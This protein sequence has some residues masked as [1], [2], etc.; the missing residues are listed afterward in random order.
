M[1]VT[2]DQCYRS[3]VSDNA[4]HNHCSAK[5]DHPYCDECE[6]L[7]RHDQALQQHLANAAVH[8]GDSD[9]YESDESDEECI[10]AVA[11][12]ILGTQVPL[13]RFNQ[14]RNTAAVHQGDYDYESEEY[15][16]DDDDN[17]DDDDPYC[18]SCNRMFVHKE[19]LYQHLSASSLHNWCFICS[20]DFRSP[21]LYRSTTPPAST[22]PR[23]SNAPS[24]R[25]SSNRLPTSPATS[26]QGLQLAY[27]PHHVTAAVHALKL[28]PTISINR[29]IAARW[30]CDHD[31]GTLSSLN[32]HLVSPAHDAK[33]FKCPHRKC[34]CQFTVIS[35]L[36]RHIESE[37]CGLAKF[38]TVKDYTHSLTS[39][40]SRMLTL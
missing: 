25:A 20:K 36:I 27:R 10:V 35:A 31:F 12:G 26:R 3:F 30:Q 11:T 7:F 2:C 5:A 1:T 38:S 21:K 18:E 6:R 34:G 15:E 29:R 28:T 19:A 24:V 14:H 23:T 17:D 39:Q 8:Q 13:S 22:R 9:E 40:F 33:Q 32:T 37:A 16:P 4:L